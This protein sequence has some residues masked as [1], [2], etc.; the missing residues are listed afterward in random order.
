MLRGRGGAELEA[1]AT[2]APDSL[3]QDGIGCPSQ[4]EHAMDK[5]VGS[6]PRVVGSVPNPNAKK[7]Q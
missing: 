6:V 4:L 5:V 2:A 3:A 1:I 7:R